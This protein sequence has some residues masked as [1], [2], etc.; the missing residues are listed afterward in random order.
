[1]SE[2]LNS[3]TTPADQQAQAPNNKNTAKRPITEA[4][5]AARRANSRKSTGP[6]TAAGKFRSSLN[7]LRHGAYAKTFTLKTED[8]ARFQS[9]I[10]DYIANFNPQSYAELEF[11]EQMATASWRRRRIATIINEK[12]NKAIDT[13]FAQIVQ[14]APDDTFGLPPLAT[15]WREFTISPAGEAEPEV[16]LEAEPDVQSETQPEPQPEPQPDPQIEEPED[17]EEPEPTPTISNEALTE[18]A[19]EH[20]ARTQPSF[21]RL[22][23]AE[24]LAAAAFR[25][26]FRGFQNYRAY[27]EQQNRRNEATDSAFFKSSEAAC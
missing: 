2:I 3:T 25:A 22:E 8:Q 20:I 14:P 24:R 5:R 26:A 16:Q 6:R 15:E 4:Q 12:I 23:A 21:F 27:I 9:V 13:V 18:L 19:Y 1:M 10:D 11:I 17:P 7:S